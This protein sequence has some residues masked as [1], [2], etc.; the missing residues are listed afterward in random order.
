M[1]YLFY[2]NSFF[3]VNVIV[4]YI[5]NSQAIKNFIN[6]LFSIFTKTVNPTGE[7]IVLSVSSADCEM[8]YQIGVNVL[9]KYRRKG[10]ALAVTSMLALKVFALGKVLFYCAA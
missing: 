2:V 1:P 3:R 6:R 9:P 7:L 8:M 4:V 5:A 10:I